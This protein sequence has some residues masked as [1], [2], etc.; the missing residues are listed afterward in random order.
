MH[1][2]MHFSRTIFLSQKPL[3]SLSG[4]YG[5]V[6]ILIYC[7]LRQELISCSAG[8]SAFEMSQVFD[9]VLGIDYSETFIH[10]ANVLKESGS[11][12]VERLI[13]VINHFR[14]R[15]WNLILKEIEL[16]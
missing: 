5:R 10:A 6:W 11:H 13:S 1:L 14:R 9:S 8:R 12:P 16:F 2:K 3:I 7:R 15:S 4:A